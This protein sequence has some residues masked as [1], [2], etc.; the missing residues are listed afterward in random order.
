MPAKT[1]NLRQKTDNGLNHKECGNTES[2]TEDASDEAS[3]DP[4][5]NPPPST[6]SCVTTRSRAKK[7]TQSFERTTRSSTD[8]SNGAKRS[9]E[10]HQ[11]ETTRPSKRGRPTST[12]TAIKKFTTQACTLMD[13]FTSNARELENT[14]F[15]NQELKRQIKRLDSALK[16][17]QE[18]RLQKEI[19][20][21][22]GKD[23]GKYVKVTDLDIQEKWGKMTY[24]IDDMVTQCLN[25]YP[26]EQ[27]RILKSLLAELE[28]PLPQ[29]DDQI[30]MLRNHILRRTIWYFLMIGIFEGEYSIWHG[31][32]GRTLTKFLA[33]QNQGHLEDTQHLQMISQIKSTAI[34]ELG[35]EIQ[36]N[37]E[38]I[39]EL[40]STAMLAVQKFITNSI[41]DSTSKATKEAVPDPTEKFQ[42]MFKGLI[43]EAAS[44]HTIM[45]KS[46]AIFLLQ[47][48]GETHDNIGDP[49]NPNDMAACQFGLPADSSRFL[50]RF[51]EAPAL[52]K[53]GNADGE[54]FHL[55]MIL[56]RSRVVLEERD[57]TSPLRTTHCIPDSDDGDEDS[58]DSGSLPHPL[59]EE[60]KGV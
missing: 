40:T 56:C 44:L 57:T 59:K 33:V 36:L 8:R 2:E 54:D 13:T 41:K 12:D 30:M 42:A 27:T 49:Y 4:E 51:V 46:K 18:N 25:E 28:T 23:S 37:E 9:H 39:D 20:Q 45:M 14:R 29:F 60:S 43:T 17:E 50:V 22:E 6:V 34:A 3:A 26:I 16:Q 10:A 11:S 24:N 5:Y 15:E 31:D 21:S 55:K 1:H 19:A 32:S 48:I 52:A 47:W 35:D 38:A 7:E 58:K 53:Y